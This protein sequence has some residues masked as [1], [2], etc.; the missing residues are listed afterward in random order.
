MKLFRHIFFIY[1][2]FRQKLRKKHRDT[3]M[4]FLLKKN[5]M[6]K[7]ISVAAT[8]FPLRRVSLIST[9]FDT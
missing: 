8:A 1:F 6:K 7:K 9:G 4:N 2:C 3:G 5:K